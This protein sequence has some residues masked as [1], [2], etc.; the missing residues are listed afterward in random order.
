MKNDKRV[1]LK[2]AIR[3]DRN[4]LK[5]IWKACPGLRIGILSFNLLDALTP[6]LT[7]YL[8][9][10]LIQELTNQRRPQRL[11]AL[12]SL[13]LFTPLVLN[14]IAKAI[15][16][17]KNCN[18]QASWWTFA[19]VFTD[20]LLY[21]DYSVLDDSKTHDLFSQIVE[22]QRWSNWGLHRAI[23]YSE[24]M[25]Y[26]VMNIVI[27]VI[28]TIPLY[29]KNVTNHAF[30]ALNHPGMAVLTFMALI[31]VAILSPFCRKKAQE[32]WVNSTEK[33]R[34]SQRIENVF[35]D[36]A[37]SQVE[38]GEDIRLYD[39]QDIIQYYAS[40][41]QM[42][43]KDSDLCKAA[44]GPMGLWSVMAEILLGLF[45]LLVYLFVAIKAYAGAFGIGEVT[46]Y[47]GSLTMLAHGFERLFFALG[48]MIN[49]A[50]FL[51][52]ISTF[53]DLPSSMYKGTLTTE[54]RSDRQYD[55]EFRNVSF[56]YPNSEAWALRN[57]S[58]KFKTG[59]RLAVVG[60]NGSG[61]TTMIKLLCRLYDPTEGEI[62]LN[63]IDIRKYKY[64]DY[65]KLFSVVFQ[66]YQLL[67]F[68]L[69]QNVAASAKYDS[70][71]IRD[72]LDKAGFTERLSELPEGLDTPLYREFDE[73]GVEIS[74]GEA[75][76]IAIAR[77]LYKNAPFI[78][79]DE[80][81][82]AL[83]PKAEAEI[84]G[85]LNEIVED[86]TAIFISHRLSSC[87]FCDE[88]AVFDE[89]QLVQKGT[90]EELLA[91]ESGKYH[92]LWTSQAKHYQ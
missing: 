71:R 28:I 5:L 39:Q 23:N 89:G 34:K 15:G 61:K 27:G 59:T 29:I 85:Q 42:F 49:N 45:T 20:K 54:K 84:Y 30:L 3:L 7:V 82:A 47:I 69:A 33:Y 55:I 37:F 80:P 21:M 44:R 10:F 24:R 68:P 32:Y 72:A 8:S 62:L 9:A 17:W 63:G 91:D 12:T 76:K 22:N 74:G 18:H 64:D 83:D 56:H 78:V 31:M 35:M 2:E 48:G 67:S 41:N 73:K 65:L 26:A 81:T 86:R 90:H 58:L 11:F 92:E 60:M 4:A 87:R 66:D 14:S 51:S 36:Y 50:P 1:S 16:H 79:L 13:C 53:M 6:Y 25:C 88:I 70:D 77:A 19:K 52:T 46:R 38:H 57:F 40:Q 43:G 75:Q